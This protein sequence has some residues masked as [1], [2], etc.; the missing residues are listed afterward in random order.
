MPDIENALV[1][2]AGQVFLSF[3]FRHASEFDECERDA[4]RLLR[5]ETQDRGLFLALRVARERRV[6]K[7][8]RLGVVTLESFMVRPQE[9][10]PALADAA[11]ALCRQVAALGQP[12]AVDRA[13]LEMDYAPLVPPR[14]RILEALAD[15]RPG[16]SDRYSMVGRVR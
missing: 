15:L 6:Q 13:L 4:L 2:T 3:G 9:E 12:I 16:R 8:T 14:D 1:L 7:E 5:D 10:W 11:V